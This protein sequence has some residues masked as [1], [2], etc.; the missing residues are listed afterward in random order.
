MSK[1]TLAKI[2]STLIQ[3]Q[4]PF[5]SDGNSVILDNENN[6]VITLAEDGSLYINGKEVTDSEFEEFVA[7]L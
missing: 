3:M 4:Q 7:N 1:Y 6:D 2:K 5:W